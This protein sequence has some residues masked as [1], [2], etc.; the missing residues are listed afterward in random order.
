MP[1]PISSL[2]SAGQMPVPLAAVAIAPARASDVAVASSSVPQAA[3]G[4]TSAEVPQEA[5]PQEDPNSGKT[6]K[7][8]NVEEAAKAFREFLKQLPSDL[9]VEKDQESGRIVYKVVNP[10]T[11]EVIR[12]YP[13]EEMLEMVRRFR[14]MDSHQGSGILLDQKS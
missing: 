9:Q 14:E 12:Q 5:V 4:R 6:E 8:I 2:G 11:K 10:V 7:T 13:P 3:P 1:D